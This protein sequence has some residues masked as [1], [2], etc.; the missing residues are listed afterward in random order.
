MTTRED[1]CC[2]GRI[3]KLL[4]KVSCPTCSS[5]AEGLTS[6]HEEN[7]I[8]TTVLISMLAFDVE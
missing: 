8:A 6:E 3:V 1:V 2:D 4:D 7:G 5:A